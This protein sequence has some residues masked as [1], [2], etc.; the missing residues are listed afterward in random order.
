MSDQPPYPYNLGTS[1]PVMP[2]PPVAEHCID[3]AAGAVTLVVEARD[4]VDDQARGGQPPAGTDAPAFDDFGASLHVVAA[5]DR[6]EYLR[7]DCFENE[8]HYHY[9]R[10]TEGRNVICR[11]DDVAEGDPIEWV[12]GRLR[13]RLPEMLEHAGA[14]ELA[15]AVRGQ[16]PEVVAAADQ[17]RGLLR[18][19]H[20][21]AVARRA[22]GSTLAPSAPDR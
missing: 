19:A 21:R 20:H 5:A 14:A 9:I 8:P 17:V 4:L 11:L 12:V 7:F 22:S 15:A 13:S 6:T 1:Y 18:E 16:I 10:P 3:V 2:I